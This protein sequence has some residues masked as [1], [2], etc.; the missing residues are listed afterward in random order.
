[1]RYYSCRLCSMYSLRGYFPHLFRF[2][3]CVFLSLHNED[4]ILCRSMEIF[5]ACWK[6]CNP[7]SP[8]I[9]PRRFREKIQ[10]HLVLTLASAW[11]FPLNVISSCPQIGLADELKVLILIVKWMMKK[12]S[13]WWSIGQ[14]WLYWQCPEWL[15]C[16]VWKCNPLWV[17][18]VSRNSGVHAWI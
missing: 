10:F 9:W 2:C 8:Y 18:L 13:A 6:P 7:F 14:P 1:M 11:L 17:P 15:Q 12:P 3:F 4:V 16:T 5:A